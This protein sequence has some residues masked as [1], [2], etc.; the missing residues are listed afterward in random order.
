MHGSH[1]QTHLPQSVPLKSEINWV[2]PDMTKKSIACYRSSAGNSYHR[3]HSFDDL[4]ATSIYIYTHAH[5]NCSPQMWRIIMD[6]CIISQN[7][8]M[9]LCFMP[10]E[11]SYFKIYIYGFT[12]IF[13]TNQRTAH[14]TRFLT[15]VCVVENAREENWQV[16]DYSLKLSSP[17]HKHIKCGGRGNLV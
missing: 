9:F 17:T 14:L 8:S 1:T 10:C 13:Q 7:S 2:S 5:V 4:S 15:Y 11:I 3:Y 6:C 16:E 12:S